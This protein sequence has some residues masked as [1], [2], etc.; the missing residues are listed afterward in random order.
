MTIDQIR[1]SGATP[2]KALSDGDKRRGRPRGTDYRRVD[3]PLHEEM[4]RMIEERIVPTLTAAAGRIAKRAFGSGTPQSK[5][6]RL[7]RTYPHER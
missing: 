3:A 4:R 6:T 1:I 5:I 7:V 2:S